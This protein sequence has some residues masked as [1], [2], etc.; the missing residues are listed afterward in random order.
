MIILIRAQ[1]K[2]D[3]WKQNIFVYFSTRILRDINK[4]FKYFWSLKVFRWTKRTKNV[5][6]VEVSE[7]ILTTK[8]LKK[9][10]GT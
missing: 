3:P 8:Q 1:I 2:I 9:T 4:Q 10:K 7:G 5:R 6:R